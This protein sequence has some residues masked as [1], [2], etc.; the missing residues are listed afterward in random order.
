MARPRGFDHFLERLKGLEKSYAVIGGGAASLLM[1]DHG[2]DFRATKDV[3]LVLLT[4]GSKELNTRIAAYV[5]EGRYKTKEATEGEPRY[6]RFQEP[7]EEK[8][9][10]QIEVFARNEQKIE[11]HEGQYIIPVQSDEIARISAIM[12]DDEYFEIITSNLATLESGATVINPIANICLKARAHRE[13][14]EKKARGEKVDSKDIEK[15]RK[16]IFR[17]TPLLSG[18]E[19]IILGKQPKA[20]LELALKHLRDM[21]EGSFKDMMKNVPAANKD[22]LLGTISKVFLGT[23]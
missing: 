23:S 16:D 14:S 9:P 13:M 22:T 4:N 10:L 8:F 18:S 2:L 1:D 19:K 11:L 6:Y 7:Q 3:D 17:I 5:K 12:L 15:H 20:D 21:S